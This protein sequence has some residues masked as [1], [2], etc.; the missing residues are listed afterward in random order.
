MTNRDREAREPSALSF[1]RWVILAIAL[2][3]LI[4]FIARS[5]RAPTEDTRANR[6]VTE[7]E[8]V[9]DEER[10]PVD[11]S[12][13]GAISASATPT[14]NGVSDHAERQPLSA[15]PD[16][17]TALEEAAP[18]EPGWSAPIQK[19]PGASTLPL[20]IGLGAHVPAGQTNINLSISDLPS[21]M[22]DDERHR[23]VAAEE[24]RRLAAHRERFSGMGIGQWRS[25]I[26]GYV[27]AIHVGNQ[28][29]LG[30]A[31]RPFLAYLK[32]MQR[33][34]YPIFADDFVEWLR[35]LPSEHPL[36]RPHLSTRIEIALDAASGAIA[37]MGV[38]LASGVTAF[39]VGVLD[40]I[41]R[42]AP[43]GPAPDGI[44]SDNGSV[45]V[46]WDFKNEPYDAC[47]VDNA[48]PAIVRITQ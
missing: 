20:A 8:I 6:A 38:V 21:I 44:A 39:D 35:T 16:N 9:V 25:A 4:V 3:A 43:F 2:H 42:A 26:E 46:Q 7:T 37:K 15:S 5:K 28:K 40:A 34:I 31:Q 19:A 24:G 33:R 12:E 18:S 41:K 10:A 22:S 23:I 30:P 29:P 48:R 13:P 11:P 1:G 47:T 32:T 36:R 27:P 17:H 14:R 45:Y